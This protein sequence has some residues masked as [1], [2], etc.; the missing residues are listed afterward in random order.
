MSIRV[1]VVAPPSLEESGLGAGVLTSTD[2]ASLFNACRQA[3]L[4]AESGLD[5]WEDSNWVGHRSGRRET[6]L[7]MHSW[8]ED[9]PAFESMVNQIRPNLLLIGAMTVCFPGAIACAKRARELLGD[10]VCIVLGGRHVNEAMYVGLDGA[11]CH[12]PSSPL[13]LMEECLV[14]PVFD[15]VF[16]GEGEM[17]I[18]WLGKVVSRLEDTRHPLNQMYR[19]IDE[20]E[21]VPGRW[22]LGWLDDGKSHTVVSRS[23]ALD[24]DSLAVPCEMFGVTAQFGV[25]HGRKTAHVF[26]DMGN[27][28]S[29]DCAFCSERRTVTGSVQ[30]ART[31]AQRLYRQMSGATRVVQEDTPQYRASAFVE[32]SI[33][34]SGSRRPIEQLVGLLEESKLDLR[35]GCQFTVDQVLEKADL[36]CSLKKAGL[37]YVFVGVETPDPEV[38]GGFSKVLK[39]RARSWMSRTEMMIELLSG[40]G[41]KC[42]VAVLFGLGESHISRMFLL[43]RLDYWRK[44][45]GNLCTVSINWAVQH[46]LRGDDGGLNYQYLRWGVPGGEWTAAFSDFGEASVLYPIVGQQA[47]ILTEVQQLA[48]LYRGLFGSDSAIS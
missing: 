10:K 22:V 14:D 9:A 34:L 40:T 48:T 35:F 16:S 21:F 44:Q 12:H 17:V 3:A 43:E 27:G 6:F 18:P 1:M 23:I 45:Y 38:V 13:R 15:I 42:G 29:H 36:L 39:N 37:D 7:L 26:S 25:F 30:Q 32:D 28:C 31:A 2:P 5:G 20:L 47:P 46:P 11:I 33:L 41:I 4:A 8:Q 24:H 19:Y